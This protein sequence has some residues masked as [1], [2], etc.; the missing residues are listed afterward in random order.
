MGERF[1][2]R[3]GELCIK[4]RLQP[5]RRQ[6]QLKSSDELTVGSSSGSK[7]QLKL[8]PRCETM[9]LSHC[10]AGCPCE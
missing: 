9:K 4:L 6:R 5:E 2:H 1:D 8:K 7:R 3:V 10:G